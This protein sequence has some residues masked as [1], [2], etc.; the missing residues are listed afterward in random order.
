MTQILHNLY[1]IV[2]LCQFKRLLSQHVTFIAIDTSL[3]EIL[4]TINNPFIFLFH[5]LSKK[6]TPYLKINLIFTLIAYK[7]YSRYILN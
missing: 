6:L 3:N 2:I 7:I 4:I 1:T 5:L